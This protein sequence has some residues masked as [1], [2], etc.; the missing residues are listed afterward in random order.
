ML[1][2]KD[3]EYDQAEALETGAD[4]FLSEPFS[5]LVLVARLRALVRRG[6]GS[7]AP[8][9]TLGDLRLDPATRECRRGNLS[10]EWPSGVLAARGAD[11]ESSPG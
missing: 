5:Y 4:D 7:A 1:T 10:I 8:V 6:S 9:L 11:A 2:A 3:G